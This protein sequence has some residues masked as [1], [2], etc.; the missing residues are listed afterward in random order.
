M[1]CCPGASCKSFARPFDHLRTWINSE[2]WVLG[3]FFPSS[4]GERYR[5]ET[6]TTWR[7]TLTS[8]LIYM[9]S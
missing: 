4:A 7:I 2:I 6:R 3:V 8:C 1:F 9:S 5:P